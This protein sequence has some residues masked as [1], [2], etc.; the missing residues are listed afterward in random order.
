M[1]LKQLRFSAL[2][3]EL[4]IKAL[5]G[6]DHWV[7]PVVMSIEGVHNGSQGPILYSAEEL[8][9]SVDNWNG[10][11]VTIYHP[12]TNNGNYTSAR[13]P[14]SAPGVVGIIYNAQMDG[15][16]L[17][18]E[19]WIDIEVLKEVS[20]V[21]YEHIEQ[22]KA[23]DV[24]IGAFQEHIVEQGEFK[25]ETYQAI[26]TNIQPDHLA[27]LPNKKGA[28]D[29]DD[30]C[31]IRVNEKNKSM[32]IFQQL[33]SKAADY[34]KSFFALNEPGMVETLEQINQLLWAMDTENIWHYLEESYED[35]VIYR[36][37]QN[38][39]ISYFRQDYTIDKDNNVVFE[40]DPVEVVKDVTFNPV[41]NLNQSVK[42]NTMSKPATPCTVNDLINNE[43]THYTEDNREWLESLSDDQLQLMAPK[44]AAAEPANNGQNSE[45]VK[46]PFAGITDPEQAIEKMPIGLQESFRSMH[47]VHKE[48]RAS[49][50]SE[51]TA[52]S[53]MTADELELYP[54]SQLEKLAEAVK[55]KGDFSLNGSAG[56]IEVNVAEDDEAKA[57]SHGIAAQ[58]KTKED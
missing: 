26:A 30:G 31:G 37:N 28:C 36:K 50:I 5:H 55:P 25:D 45:G 52:N 4:Q 39:D 47:R 40:G 17:K 27:I 8:A 43:A 54:E 57:M 32:N 15:A 20:P 3:Y 29:W 48:K 18:G 19:A 21:A 14:E 41:T 10:A 11:P 56:A 16:K 42:L 35:H 2:N 34:F 9:K 49:L 58:R 1:D 24:S 46:D 33:G 44:E 51:I 38:G 12:Q 23:V 7:V 22:T 53:E 13:T 6:R